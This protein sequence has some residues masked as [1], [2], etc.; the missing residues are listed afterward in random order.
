MAQAATPK[1]GATISED[2]IGQNWRF[3]E[4]YRLKAVC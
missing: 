4:L 1:A 2:E 3:A